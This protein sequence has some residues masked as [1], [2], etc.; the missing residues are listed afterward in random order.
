MT[1][2]KDDSSPIN[3]IVL[4]SSVLAVID[5]NSFGLAYEIKELP[6]LS[7]CAEISSSTLARTEKIC[8]YTSKS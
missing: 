7:S 1:T 2:R 5:P 3:L 4:E 6:N 8:I